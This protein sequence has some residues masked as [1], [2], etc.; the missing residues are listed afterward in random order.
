MDRKSKTAKPKAR[1]LE[2]AWEGRIGWEELPAQ[3][4][5]QVRDELMRL[6]MQLAVGPD[7]VEVDDDDGER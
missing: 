3:L 4:R 7:V 5:L 1:Q 2:L 6:L